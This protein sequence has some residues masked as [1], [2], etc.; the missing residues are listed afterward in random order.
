MLTCMALLHK[1]EDKDK[2]SNKAQ[3]ADTCWKLKT[4][5]T[6]E[7]VIVAKF[8]GHVLHRLAYSLSNMIS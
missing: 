7:F 1:E 4:H 6:G 5:P 8:A 2:T 3:R